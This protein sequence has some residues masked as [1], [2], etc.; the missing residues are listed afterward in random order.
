MP[1]GEREV[2]S[3]PLSDDLDDLFDPSPPSPPS[4]EDAWLPE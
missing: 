4:L 2:C 1:E 3:L